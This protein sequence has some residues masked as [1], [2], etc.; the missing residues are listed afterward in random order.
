MKYVFAFVFIFILGVYIV[1][2]LWWLILIL[3]AV[4]FCSI[5]FPEEFGKSK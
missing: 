3:A 4:G 1:S 2:R 5:F